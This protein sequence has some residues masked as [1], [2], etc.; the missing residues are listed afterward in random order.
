MPG[1]PKSGRGFWQRGGGMREAVT[2]GRGPGVRAV[3]RARRVP[4]SPPCVAAGAA[5]EVERPPDWRWRAVPGK[6]VPVCAKGR[7]SWP[8]LRDHDPFTLIWP[9]EVACPSGR[10]CSTRNAVWCN[11]H[12]GFKSQRYRHGKPRGPSLWLGP[13]GVLG[14]GV[15]RR[16]LVGHG[17]RPGCGHSNR[18]AGISGGAWADRPVL[19][20][21]RIGKR[22]GRACVRSAAPSRWSFVLQSETVGAPCALFCKRSG[23]LKGIPSLCKC[24]NTCKVLYRCTSVV[25]L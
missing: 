4:G 11:S 22:A 16:A 19:V 10:R 2:A 20:G 12:P 24:Y 18:V 1:Q 3:A 13:R 8:D 15:S 9:G 17:R 21:F 25:S 6:A 5:L 14:A 7:S 23:D